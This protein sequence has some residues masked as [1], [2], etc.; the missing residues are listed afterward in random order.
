MAQIGFGPAGATSVSGAISDYVPKKFSALFNTDSRAISSGAIEKIKEDGTE[1]TAT[2]V[3][4]CAE[5]VGWGADFSRWPTGSSTKMEK[6]RA[7]PKQIL[8]VVSLGMAA[9][10]AK[11]AVKEKASYVETQVSA[12]LKQM[13]MH[14]AKGIFGGNSGIPQTTNSWSGTGLSSTLVVD[15]LDVSMFKEGASYNWVPATLSGGIQ[16]SYTVRVREIQRQTVGSAS[17]NVA[18]RVTF[19][20]DVINKATGAVTTLHTQTTLVGDRYYQ[21]GTYEGFAGETAGATAA[22]T[23]NVLTS[24]DDIA[25]ATTVLGFTSSTLAGWA[26]NTLAAGGAYNQELMKSL[27]G[28]IQ[29]VS[30][31]MPTHYF[32]SPAVLQAHG[33]S[34]QIIG[35]VF[36][37]TG[38]LSAATPISGGVDKYAGNAAYTCNGK[39]LIEDIMC[40]AGT[41]V[42]HNRDHVKLAE[43]GPVQVAQNGAGVVDQTFNAV[44][45]YLNA[46]YELV[47]DM[48]SSVGTLTGIT[49]L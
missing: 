12:R 39:P 34:F 46:Q 22:V 6:L 5:D 8:A 10:L 13:S 3:P 25:T 32:C 30:G 9:S 15:F 7:P 49:G 18:G 1:W 33:A 27:A 42:A 4:P 19:I 44:N 41:M 23:G 16:K 11:M 14:L 31:E 35:S 47:T 38:G 2:A 36:G 24:F 43:Y 21:R 45:Y 17:A 37:T 40:Q 28:R 26:G 20:H 29:A 48:R